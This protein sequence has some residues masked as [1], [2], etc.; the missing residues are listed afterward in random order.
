MI[1]DVVE[2]LICVSIAIGNRVVCLRPLRRLDNA[3]GESEI[4]FDDQ[5]RR[6]QTDTP[7]V[8]T[9]MTWV[10]QNAQINKSGSAQDHRRGR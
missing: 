8:A 1:V 5:E 7:G 2:F 3:I 6:G 10:P 9:D 4:S